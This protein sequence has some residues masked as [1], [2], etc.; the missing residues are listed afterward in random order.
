MSAIQRQMG[1][2]YPIVKDT[3]ESQYFEELKEQLKT[4]LKD[5]IV[6][7]SGGYIFRAFTLC[8][9]EDVKV[10]ILGQEPYCDGTAT[11]LS[12]ANDNDNEKFSPSLNIIRQELIESIHG[13]FF[14]FNHGLEHWSQ[15][16]VLL[17][18]TALTVKQNLPGSHID[19][20]E[21]FTIDFIS[22]FSKV[23][24]N[25]IYLLWGSEAQR[26]KKH[27]HGI[28]YILEA[29]HPNEDAYNVN[30]KRKFLGCDHFNKTN[31][32]INKHYTNANIDWLLTKDQNNWIGN[33]NLKDKYDE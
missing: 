6:Y 8:S 24:S 28:N 19:L 11:G 9:I 23:R 22:K 12:F 33:A 32:L 7:P 4:D 21:K 14:P 20:W 27:I 3:I 30:S 13:Q 25:I 10:V 18:N 15:Q 29:P 1:D 17:L 26:Y 2:W 5:G 16:G 31:K